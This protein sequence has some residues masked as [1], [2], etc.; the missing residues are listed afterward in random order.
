[1]CITHVHGLRFVSRA[2]LLFAAAALLGGSPA[3]V[4]AGGDD[5]ACQRTARYALKSCRSEAL[6][7]F[8]LAMGNCENLSERDDRVEC[9]KE[10]K[11]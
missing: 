7:D 4:R 11:A 3:V 8:Y 1:M 6:E 9:R 5:G 10:A 2:R